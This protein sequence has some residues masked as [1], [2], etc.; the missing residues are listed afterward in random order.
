MRSEF[1][2]N[3]E[4]TAFTQLLLLLTADNHNRLTALFLGPAGW[5]GARRTSG[6]Y[7]A[8]ED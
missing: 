4:F 2:S 5:A 1:T 8:R 6:L 7:G 3:T